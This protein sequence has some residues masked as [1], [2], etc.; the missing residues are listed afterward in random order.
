LESLM[1]TLH[2]FEVKVASVIRRL[3]AEILCSYAESVIIRA[4][5]ILPGWS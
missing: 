5:R 1:C 2:F 3:F 4:L